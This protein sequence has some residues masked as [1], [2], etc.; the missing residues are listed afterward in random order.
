MKELMKQIILAANLPEGQN[1]ITIEALL[2]AAKE[3]E[4][5]IS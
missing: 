5:G 1:W 3:V 2:K 4:N